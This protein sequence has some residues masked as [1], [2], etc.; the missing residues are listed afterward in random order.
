[1]KKRIFRIL[2]TLAIT[3]ACITCLT[4]CGVVPSA[5]VYFKIDSGYTIYTNNMYPDA[6]SHV[7][8][9]ASQGDA[10]DYSKADIEISF[11]PRIMGPETVKVDGHDQD[12]TIVDISDYV[13]I[14]IKIKKSAAIYSSDKGIYLNGNLLSP[15][16]STGS[17]T[18]LYLLFENVAL[19][20]GNP[21]GHINGVVNCIEYK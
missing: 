5:W 7:Y 17:S 13:D 8:H 10:D 15:D 18:S 4:G 16:Q 19:E 12:A 9:F 6:G 21:N 20:R 2:L 1:M 3:L 14:H 11:Y